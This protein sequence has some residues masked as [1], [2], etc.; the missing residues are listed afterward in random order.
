MLCNFAMYLMTGKLLLIDIE[1]TYARAL[2]LEP[3]DYM[4]NRIFIPT[5][6]LRLTAELVR[7]V[8]SSHGQGQVRSC[9]QDSSYTTK[10]KHGGGA[11]LRRG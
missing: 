9:C 8:A 6:N 1:K 7:K 11:L 5:A 4:H 3:S 10:S 2:P